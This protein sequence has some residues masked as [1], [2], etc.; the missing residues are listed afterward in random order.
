MRDYINGILIPLLQRMQT[1]RNVNPSMVNTLG[2]ALS[3]LH[4]YARTQAA[5]PNPALPP[6]T[7]NLAGNWIDLALREI[8]SLNVEGNE[9]ICSVTEA[10]WKA[11]GIMNW[12][13]QTNRGRFFFRGEHHSDWNLVCSAFRNG[14]TPDPDNLLEVT[15]SEI[16][17]LRRF[18]ATVQT[19]RQL[20][21]SVFPDGRLLDLDSADW[22]ALMQHY[23]GG[24]RLIDI[25]SSVFCAL[26]HACA[27]WDGTVNTSVD[28]ALYLF[29][30]E[31]W[32]PAVLYPEIVRGQNVG[33]TDQLYPTV[34]QYFNVDGHPDIVRFRESFHRN[35][36]LLAQDGY[37]LWQPTFDMPLNLNQFF[38][39]RVPAS[40]KHHILSELYSVGYTAQRIVRGPQG[41]SA[42]ENICTSI[43]VSP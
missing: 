39:F 10:Q 8:E 5:V 31:D 25:S 42:H 38:K 30:R 6:N 9:A 15:E 4:S 20:Y 16:A 23:A 24:T 33:S 17:D 3:E 37:F 7:T 43:G 1:V 11:N 14:H 28:G 2:S 29:P 13:H 32:R 19:D 26:F 35:D 21:A 12:W 41:E 27:G 40:R 34:G 18:Q 22:W 36:R